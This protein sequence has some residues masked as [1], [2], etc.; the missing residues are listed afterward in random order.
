MKFT[1]LTQ[2]I[3]SHNISIDMLLGMAV[4]MFTAM[5]R[6]V[7]EEQSQREIH[8]VRGSCAGIMEPASELHANEVW[9][10]ILR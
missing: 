5:K 1:P 4:D 7:H 9:R 10:V 3:I 6:I 2:V 8:M